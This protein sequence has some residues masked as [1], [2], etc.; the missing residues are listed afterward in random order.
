MLLLLN[1][2]GQTKECCKAVNVR[3]ESC[4]RGWKDEEREAERGREREEG[5]CESDKGGEQKKRERRRQGA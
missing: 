1:D 3:G 2:A 4:E 5:E